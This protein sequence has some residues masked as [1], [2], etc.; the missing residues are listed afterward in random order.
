MDASTTHHRPTT[1]R[2]V[3]VGV[4]AVGLCVVGTGVAAAAAPT[5]ALSRS[6]TE[7]L[8]S[9]GVDWS[10]MP[11]G[12]TPE[13][14][15]A[16]WGAG[17]STE[18]VEALGALWNLEATETKARAGQLILD[19]QPVPVAPTGSATSDADDE[20]AVLL[21]DEQFEAF[22]G[23]GYTEEDIEALGA[24]WSTEYVE[25]KAR[26]GQMI[27]DGQTPPVAPTGTPAGQ[28]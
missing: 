8:Q 9:A 11:D 21:S 15:E 24:I 22:W 27:L 5:S 12:Y 1:R 19:G 4:V 13:Q 25:T 7:I 14:Y 16:F 18:D 10:S 26:A 3:A 20:G 28:S 17:Y 23:A 2:F 6:V